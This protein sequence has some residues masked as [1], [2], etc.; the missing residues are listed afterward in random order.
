MVILFFFDKPKGLI[1]RMF[2]FLSDLKKKIG[3]RQR[4]KYI[5][6]PGWVLLNDQIKTFHKIMNRIV[7]LSWQKRRQVSILSI[8]LVLSNMLFLD[9]CL[10]RKRIMQ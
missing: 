6:S 10:A 7:A 8:Y 1:Y 3:I 2:N 9:K 4:L 5:G